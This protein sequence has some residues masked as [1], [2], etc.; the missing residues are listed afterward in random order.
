MMTRNISLDE[1][2]R[3]DLAA[4]AMK[5]VDGQRFD[6]IIQN[7]S[8]FHEEN[9]YYNWYHENTEMKLAYFIKHERTNQYNLTTS[10][11]SG[12]VSTQNIG[13]IFETNNGTIQMN[14]KIYVPKQHWSDS[15]NIQLNLRIERNKVLGVNE[16]LTFQNEDLSYK[17]VSHVTRNATNLSIFTNPGYQTAYF[18]RINYKLTIHNSIKDHDNIPGIRLKWY[19]TG[20]NL[21]LESLYM[22]WYA[23]CSPNRSSSVSTSE[24]FIWDQPK[25]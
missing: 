14:I 20:N 17:H 6:E 16:S 25:M 15:D 2:S 8:I 7:L 13:K 21:D 3:Q 23:H 10:A 19:Y 9:R 24:N 12:G 4:Y 5:L 22:G 11:A 18:G 1:E